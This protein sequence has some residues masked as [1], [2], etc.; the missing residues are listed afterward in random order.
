MAGFN[1][2][3]FGKGPSIQTAPTV[4]RGASQGI[5]QLLQMGLQGLQNPY[6]GFEPI[7]Q[8]ARSQFAQTTVPSLA[9][10]FTSMGNNSL[11]SPALLGQLG[12]AG[13]GLEE[14]LASLR[15]QYSLQNQGQNLNLAQLGLTPQ[16]QNFQQEGQPGYFASA[17]QSGI[18]SI[19]QLL[20]SYL[21]GGLSGLGSS[22]NA[23]GGKFQ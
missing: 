22:V 16:F 9:E 14:A 3:F 12:S 6:K 7:E 11:S 13:A 20:L 4:T 17:G 5:D 2:I 1:D 15:S 10:R 18:N 23:F 21:T 8:R 19:L